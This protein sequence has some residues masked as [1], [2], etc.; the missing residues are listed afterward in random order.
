MREK[1]DLDLLLDSALA[2][3]AD[4]GADSGLE[5]RVLYALAE[6]RNTGERRRF[7]VPHRWWLDGAIIVPVAVCFVVLW[8]S[9]P[10]RVHAPSIQQQAS[11]S[12]AS[13]SSPGSQVASDSRPPA[14]RALRE[15]NFS[16]AV[17]S[18]R[19]SAPE[20]SP[21]PKLD[22]FPTPKPLTAEER[23]LFVVA[24]QAPPQVR[25]AIVKAQEQNKEPLHIAAIHI[26]PLE[27]LT[28]SQP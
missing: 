18:T 1:D 14:H 20:T 4:P 10:R 2:T 12:H 16:P 25:Q 28:D 7:R 6:A 26:P 5:Q 13:S 19:A 21:L 22:V 9:I 23:A 11:Q 27:P 3:Y 15:H 24:V 8:L 17:P